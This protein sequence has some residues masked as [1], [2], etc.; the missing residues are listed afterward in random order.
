MNNKSNI[1]KA[2][3]TPF[4]FKNYE[5]SFELNRINILKNLIPVGNGKTAIDIGCGPGYFSKELTNKN[6][7]TTSIDTDPE[8]IKIAKNYAHE[9]HLGDALDILSNLSESQYDLVL[10]LE[11]IE[12]MPKPQGEKL[13]MRII[14]LLKPH[15]KLI[16]S[17]PNKFS[18]EGLGGYYWGE[19]IRGWGKW[20]AW[21]ASHVYIYSSMEIQKILKM[22]GFVI[23]R[24]TGYYYEG[25]FPVIG[26]WKLPLVKTTRFPFNRL[27]F[28]T[29]IE[30]HKCAVNQQQNSLETY[31]KE[32]TN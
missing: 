10:C 1:F 19:K 29:I 4:N 26:Q 3:H 24:I 20:T 25:R 16:I 5:S 15:G 22:C 21:D 31:I 23:D 2:S 17:T 11:L 28:N 9:T 8:N 13:L 18:L 6:W 30:C 14:R 27:G 12:H 32:T 7:R